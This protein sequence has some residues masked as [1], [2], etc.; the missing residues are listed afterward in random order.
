MKQSFAR[1]GRVLTQYLKT[2][3][4]R[5]KNRPILVAESDG[6]VL[7]ALVIHAEGGNAVVDGW[8]E[9]R[10]GEI[11]VAVA[12][13][14]T[15]LRNSVGLL[16]NRGYMIAP[17]LVSALL[18]LPVE[19]DKPRPPQQ[20]QELIRWEMDPFIGEYSELW[21]IGAILQG[22]GYLTPEQ[23]GLVAAELELR[24]AESGRSLVRYGEI[25]LSQALINREQLEECLAI[26]EKLV[27]QDVTLSCGWGLQ[28]WGN[29]EDNHYAWLTCAMPDLRRKQWFSAFSASGVRL[30][31][32]LS[33]LGSVVP[34]LAE[35]QDSQGE[36]LLLE[37]QQEQIAC[38]RIVDDKTV[39][40]LQVTPRP[41]D[42]NELNSACI[43][44]C[45][46]QLRPD[47]DTLWLHSALPLPAG[48]IP[49]LASALQREVKMP[50]S[51]DLDPGELP[52]PVSECLSLYG[53]ALSLLPLH[54]KFQPV[55]VPATDPPPPLW[56]NLELWRYAAP[57][58]LCLGLIGHLL[59]GHWKLEQTER[60]QFRLEAERSQ[61]AKVSAAV[62]QMSGEAQALNR[63]IRETEKTLR[64][65]G[66]KLTLIE[67]VLV[68][69]KN[70]VPQFLRA[71][72][73]SINPYV[74]VDQLVESQ[75]PPGF[76]L[77][78]WA[79]HD[80]SA[81]QFAKQLETNMAALGYMVA[82]IELKAAG[83]R[84]GVRGYG[85]NIWLIP[86]AENAAAGD[87]QP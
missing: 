32:F 76:Q 66:D 23:R 86:I 65:V 40:S 38:L 34:L 14:C 73:A 13:V 1:V 28:Q 82:D 16:P 51:A 69:R 72:A 6:F 11:S 2:G 39:I 57:V 8:A 15:A 26:Q 50:A 80:A 7:R 37:L 12:E 33:G 60:E 53:L 71:L 3:M 64:E 21:S 81:Q 22:R 77:A 18:E 63:E 79:I 61:K 56:K 19:P 58:V 20:M 67:E 31:R 9:S 59:W 44:L 75:D 4:V 29:S 55:S 54:K 46:E 74:V 78:T 27:A 43:A 35:Q 10:A 52:L 41:L 84:T 17:G 42:E 47:I 24:H 62:N 25:A 45:S 70:R 30:D 83:G 5:L 85:A 68:E 87:K 49:A 48:L 36:R